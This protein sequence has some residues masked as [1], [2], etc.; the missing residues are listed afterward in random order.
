MARCCYAQSW[1]VVALCEQG[2]SPWIDLRARVIHWHTLTRLH[3]NA[4]AAWHGACGGS[5]GRWSTDNSC[6][7]WR[8]D[9]CE[10]EILAGSLR[11]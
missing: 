9:S 3:I 4:L 1:R 6:Q 5:V 7:V 8:C 2:W 11:G 10:R